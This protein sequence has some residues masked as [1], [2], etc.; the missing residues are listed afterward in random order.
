MSTHRVSKLLCAAT[1][2]SAVALAAATASAQTAPNPDATQPVAHEGDH[3]RFR[4][5]VGATT[6]LVTQ[7]E[8]YSGGAQMNSEL[9]AVGLSLRLGAQLDDQWAVY[10]QGAAAVGLAASVR[11]G[12]LFEITPRDWL[13]IGSGLSLGYFA[14]PNLSGMFGNTPA[15]TSEAWSLGVPVRL[16]LNLPIHRSES[17]RRLATSF[18]VELTPAYSFGGYQLP[19]GLQLGSVAGLSFEMY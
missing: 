15:P 1:T 10:Y 3:S 7:E 18:S 19:A 13:S 14:A 6:G 8:S 17:G 4:F 12:V 5:G 16:A 11:N 9:T 2:F